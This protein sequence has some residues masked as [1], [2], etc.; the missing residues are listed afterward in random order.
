MGS[1]VE[2]SRWKP[3]NF[4]F[5]FSLEADLG[6]RL[7]RQSEMTLKQQLYKV[8]GFSPPLS[9]R[10]SR[11][12]E[13]EKERIFQFCWACIE[14]INFAPLHL[15]MCGYFFCPYKKERK[16]IRTSHKEL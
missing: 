8:V 4:T 3:T 14:C 6:F 10:L 15:I 7:K 2:E 16:R 11:E 13:V 5:H 9:I 1:I 12:R